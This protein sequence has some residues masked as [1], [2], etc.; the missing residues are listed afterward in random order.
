MIETIKITVMTPTLTP[1]M[2]NDERS[3]FARSVSKAIRADSLM[4]SNR[5]R[6]TERSQDSGLRTQESEVA[7]HSICISCQQAT[8]LFKLL[9]QFTCITIIKIGD[10]DQIVTTLFEGTLRDI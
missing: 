1:S 7:H 6:K 10:Q 5:I 8:E 3:L 9:V 4:S 2:V